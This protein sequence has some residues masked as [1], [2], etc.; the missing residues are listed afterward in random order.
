MRSYANTNKRLA[1]RY[2]QWMAALHYV[3]NTQYFYRRAIGRFIQ[4]LGNR[5]IASVTHLEVRQFAAHVS[6][7]GTSLD[8]TY[9]YLGVLRLFY[10]F[11]HLGGVVSYVAPRLVK[12]RRPLKKEPRQLSESEIQRF[13]AACRTLRERALIEFL[14]GTGCRSSEARHLRVRD[15]DFTARRA[16]VVGKF[17]K[18]RIVLLTKSATEA[19]R[20]Y[21]GTRQDGF[22]FQEDR[23]IQRGILSTSAG[24]WVGS[25]KDYGRR[26][27]KRSYKTFGK[28]DVVPYERAR[29][30]F[31]SLL[32]GVNLV[33]PKSRQALNNLAIREVFKC[34]GYR[35]GLKNV[36]PHMLRRSF[37]THLYDH[38]AGLEVI[39]A[40]MGHAWLNTTVKYT[41]M[42]TG[43]LV[44][45][46]EQC[47]PR[48]KMNVE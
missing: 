18:V 22:V 39:Q 27:L 24:Y 38:G 37:A 15:V 11:L 33:R 35:A 43:R 21:I 45:T 16:R 13:I 29:S 44:K 42:S 36:G 12:L 7:E 32:K 47:H 8:L 23:P 4:F 14:Y 48:E 26:R 6:E 30:K 34:V 3:P 5:S 2:D 46:F 10:D 25:W 40:L 31:E 9:R 41:R 20:A 28:A 19:I 1:K 17:Q